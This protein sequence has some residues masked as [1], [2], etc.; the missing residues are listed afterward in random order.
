[1]KLS[2]K[3]QLTKTV[4][5]RKPAYYK[6]TTDSYKDIESHFGYQLL[7][8]HIEEISSM[9]EVGCGNG[10][11]LASIQKVS[12]TI[13][14]WGIDVSAL[15]IA[16]AKKTYKTKLHVSVADAET[17]DLHKKFDLVYSFFT[18]EHLDKPEKVFKRMIAHTKKGGYLY[19]VCPN[20]GSLIYPSPCYTQGWIKR[21]I[22]SLKRDFHLLSGESIKSFLW[23]PVE[24]IIDT[25][26]SHIMDHDTTVEPYIY[27]L[28]RYIETSC[29][30]LQVVSADSGWWSAGIGKASLKYVLAT[31]PLR[32]ASFF[33]MT[34]FCYWGPRCMIL[35]R[36]V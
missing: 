3:E 10:S 28:R 8:P 13:E 16:S 26:M 24:P 9:L 29:P 4:W 15:A 36:K 2:K 7:K 31:I 35:V 33:G 23:Q 11:V 34:P 6:P 27:S 14:A 21:T 5:N 18:F 12:P 30:D 22:F 19:I 1:M 20:Y 25:E 17:F 32:I